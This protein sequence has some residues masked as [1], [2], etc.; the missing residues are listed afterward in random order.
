MNP[1]ILVLAGATSINDFQSLILM[2][3][4][5]TKLRRFTSPSQ[6][7]L[8]KPGLSLRIPSHQRI[9]LYSVDLSIHTFYIVLYSIIFSHNFKNMISIRLSLVKIEAIIYEQQ[10]G[11]LAV[12]MLCHE[13]LRVSG[14]LTLCRQ[15]RPSSRR[16]H[17]REQCY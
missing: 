13:M 3:A 9:N 15:L 10:I 17:V 5:S 4:T 6:S 2:L 7:H 12:G 11:I 8:V 14:G 1:S 16:E